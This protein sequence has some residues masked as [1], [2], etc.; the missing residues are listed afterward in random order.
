MKFWPQLQECN[1]WLFLGG[2]SVLFNALCESKVSMKN[3]LELHLILKY[4]A[5][6]IFL[7]LK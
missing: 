7:I 6:R 4:N 5:D 3:V 1:F 2:I